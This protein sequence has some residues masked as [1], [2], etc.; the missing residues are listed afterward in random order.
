MILNCNLKSNNLDKQ[1]I[2][3]QMSRQLY[4]TCIIDIVMNNSENL[5]PDIY[6]SNDQV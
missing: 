5:E 2:E 1:Q 4:V 6:Q 3:L